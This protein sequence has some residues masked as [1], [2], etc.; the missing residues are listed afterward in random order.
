MRPWALGCFALL[1]TSA[2]LLLVGAV[3]TIVTLYRAMR[4]GEAERASAA[5]LACYMVL[6][7]VTMVRWAWETPPQAGLAS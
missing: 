2:S 5:W 7:A 6:A 1:T 3:V 4:I